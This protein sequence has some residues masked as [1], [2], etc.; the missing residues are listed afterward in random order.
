MRPFIS[1]VIAVLNRVDT[2][3]EAIESVREQQFPDKELLVIDGGSTDG[4]VEAVRDF[5]GDLS[6]FESRPDLGIAHAWNK[7]LAVARGQWILFLGADDSL[8]DR[9]VLDRV[10]PHLQ[11]AEGKALVV[12]GEV[13][14]RGRDG[15][16]IEIYNQRW[17]RR[18]FLRYGMNLSHQGVFHHKSLFEHCGPFDETFRIAADYEL[19]LRWIK[20]HDP[21]PLKGMT[22]CGVR[23]GGMS[24]D[25]HHAMATLREFERARRK[26]GLEGVTSVW[27]WSMFKASLK[28]GL[29]RAFGPKTACT[30]VD[31]YRIV[32][33]RPRKWTRV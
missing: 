31:A 9:N 12:F 27:R 10:V 4:T 33:G 21:L 3:R 17:S 8:W 5:A 14:C 24:S 13:A 20:N 6:Y 30:L 28:A 29:F 15:R 25:P 1:V 11:E 7:A 16:V 32:T 26:N 2:V 22:V 19:L 18:R 23:H